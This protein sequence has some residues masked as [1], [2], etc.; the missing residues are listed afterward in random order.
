MFRAPTSGNQSGKEKRRQAAALPKRQE[1]ADSSAASGGLGMTPYYGA[2]IYLGGLQFL[3]RLQVEPAPGR[4][5]TRV[6]GRG[7]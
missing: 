3:S 7:T 2:D 1:K 5:R 6:M 4:A